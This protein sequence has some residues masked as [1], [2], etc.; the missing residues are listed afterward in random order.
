MGSLLQDE[1]ESELG[2]REQDGQF[3]GWGSGSVTLA[4][5][6]AAAGS[7][8]GGAALVKAVSSQLLNSLL[9][10]ENLTQPINK[11]SSVPTVS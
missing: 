11:G 5:P 4:F 10:L 8:Q 6:E 3:R 7:S 1:M 9:H 2:R